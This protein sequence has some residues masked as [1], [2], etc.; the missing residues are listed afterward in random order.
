MYPPPIGRVKQ[1]GQPRGVDPTTA[2]PWPPRFLFSSDPAPG[3]RYPVAVDRDG[4]GI[5]NAAD[6]TPGTPPSGTAGPAGGDDDRS[7]SGG[8]GALELEA[9]LAVLLGRRVQHARNYRAGSK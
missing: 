5:A 7:G 6:T 3:L 9:L 1:N 4:D 2:G 8:C